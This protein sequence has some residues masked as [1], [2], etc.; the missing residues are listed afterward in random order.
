MSPDFR[1]F[2]VWRGKVNVAQNKSRMLHVAPVVGQYEVAR[3]IVRP[4]NAGS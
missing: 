3:S 2:T 4:R 1:A